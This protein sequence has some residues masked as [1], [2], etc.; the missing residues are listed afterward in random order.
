[1]ELLLWTPSIDH[2]L[3][4]VDQWSMEVVVL[5]YYDHRMENPT[6]AL[7]KMYSTG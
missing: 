1:M 4:L 5:K 2:L 3:G 6:A 7:P